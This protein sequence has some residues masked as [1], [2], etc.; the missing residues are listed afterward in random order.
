MK[1]AWSAGYL[2]AALKLDRS[3][4]QPIV[5]GEMRFSRG[6]AF[7]SPQGGQADR[8]GASG[9][10]GASERGR[11]VLDSS[12]VSKA[13]T[14][15]TARKDGSSLS[16]SLSRLELQVCLQALSPHPCIKL[17]VSFRP[18]TRLE[19]KIS[20]RV[21]SPHQYHYFEKITVLQR[22]C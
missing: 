6:T 15:L 17:H 1:S 13:F 21:L 4:T 12:V 10:Q 9:A 14:A 18:L 5:S 8:A 22:R 20:H 19:L 11:T 2:D 7:L 3:L 16:R